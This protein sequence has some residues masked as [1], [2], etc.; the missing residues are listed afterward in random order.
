MPL[1]AMATVLWPCSSVALGTG[2][3]AAAD[4]RAAD[5]LAAAAGAEWALGCADSPW[6]PE[7]RKCKVEFNISA[8]I[9]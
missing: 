3:G 4:A 2:A 7:A 9:S 6:V 5:A 1:C 8:K